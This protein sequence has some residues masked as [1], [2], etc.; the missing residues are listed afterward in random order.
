[1]KTAQEF[2]E[3]LAKEE[4][5]L[6]DGRTIELLTPYFQEALDQILQWREGPPTEEGRWLCEWEGEN[7]D[8]YDMAAIVE[9]KPPFLD[10]DEIRCH[11]G[12][13]PEPPRGQK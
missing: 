9:G 11:F 2:A 13:I 7:S 6:S 5:G 3:E 8:E 4:L 10:G 12:P 1:M